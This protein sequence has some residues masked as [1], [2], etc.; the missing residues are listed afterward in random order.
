MGASKAAPSVKSTDDKSP[1]TF[2]IFD[3]N[4]NG[5]T[6]DDPIAKEITKRTGV[7]LQYLPNAGVADEKLNLML[8]SNDIPDLVQISR[9]SDPMN[10]YINAKAVIPLNDLI[11]KYGADIKKNYGDTLKKTKSDDGKNYYL[12]DWFNSSV[13]KEPV[14][15]F[16]MRKDYLKQIGVSQDKIDGTTPFTA[17]EFEN[18]LKEFKQKV[19]KVNGQE[20]VPLTYWQEN[21]NSGVLGSFQGMYGLTAYTVD[22]SNNLK[23]SYRDPKYLEMLKYM[24]KLQSEGL[25]D[26]E[27]PANKKALYL[28]K[29]TSGTVLGTPDAYWNPCRCRYQ[30]LRN[31]M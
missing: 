20:S 7:T 11:D 12:A 2:T 26:K 10:K 6:F 23:L 28:Q 3:N 13:Q 5:G 9:G 19:P 24:N 27:W 8:A 22:S 15:G 14:F 1:I 21:F 4:H 16:L 18:I 29:L 17:D 31:K 25:V 30:Y